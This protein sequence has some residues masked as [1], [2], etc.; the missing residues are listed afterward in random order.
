MLELFAR[1][2]F[3]NPDELLCDFPIA[4][5]QQTFLDWP[6]YLLRATEGEVDAGRV[7][8]VVLALVI[9]RHPELLEAA[10]LQIDANRTQAHNPIQFYI[11]T[12]TQSIGERSL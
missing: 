4:G 3:L 1:F 11:E 7:P 9:L 5:A 12:T 2:D 10:V 8:E 6:V